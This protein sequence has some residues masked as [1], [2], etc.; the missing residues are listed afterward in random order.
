M[1]ITYNDAFGPVLDTGSGT[2]PTVRANV[3]VEVHAS[4][5][6]DSGSTPAP[7]TTLP[8]SHGPH[9]EKNNPR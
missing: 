1:A 6:I 8:A 5:E 7:A 9:R 3:E 2:Q 4:A